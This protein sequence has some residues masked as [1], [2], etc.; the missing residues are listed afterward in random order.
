MADLG[1]V[2]GDGGGAVAAA[3]SEVGWSEL[4]VLL[5]RLVCSV[6]LPKKLKN[7]EEDGGCCWHG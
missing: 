6:G 7:E 4:E 3:D 5:V 2:C 1:C